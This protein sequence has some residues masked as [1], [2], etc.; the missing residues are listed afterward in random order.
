MTGADYEQHFP[1]PRAL[2]PAGSAATMDQLTALIDA[3]ATA[4][5]AGKYQELHLA[6]WKEHREYPL[7]GSHVELA[8]HTVTTGRLFDEI[9]R[10]SITRLSWRK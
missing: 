2:H 5:G 6:L 9:D 7:H 3:A 1:H 8:K 10:L 4:R